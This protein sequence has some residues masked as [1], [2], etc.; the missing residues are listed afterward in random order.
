M[1]LFDKAAQQATTWVK[2]MMNE[3]HVTDAN[4]A[5]HALRAGLHAL[6]DRLPV[7]EAAQLSAQMPLVIR[8]LF[9]EGWDPTGKPLRIRHRAEFLSL[10]REKYAPRDD[11]AAD[12]IMVA[13]FRVLD[14]RVSTGEVMNVMLTLPQEIAQI[15]ESRAADT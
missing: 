9:F 15:V 13:L 6:R 5:L 12:E 7:E 2:D 14:R 8:G 4:K 11:A 1:H 10:V 3:L